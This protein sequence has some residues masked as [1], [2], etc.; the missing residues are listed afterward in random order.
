MTKKPAEDTFYRSSTGHY[1]GEIKKEVNKPKEPVASKPL[2]KT[3]ENVDEWK[4][5]SNKRLKEEG[6]S[7]RVTNPFIYNFIIGV[8]II[9]IIG[10]IGFFMWG[11]YNDKFNTDVDV[12]CAD[13]P[14]IE[15]PACPEQICDVTCADIPACPE[16][17]TDINVFIDD[18]SGNESE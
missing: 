14:E 18:W 17:P 11:T 8:L 5:E 13:M 4:E 16:F 7:E 12:K 15:I 3:P 10:G 1:E 9:V 2:P 6:Y